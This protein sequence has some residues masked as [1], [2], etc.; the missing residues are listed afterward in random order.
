MLD[1]LLLPHKQQTAN[2]EEQVGTRE[3][4]FQYGSM[5]TPIRIWHHETPQDGHLD[6]RRKLAHCGNRV[7][8]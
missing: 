6:A 4:D 1:V 5:V 7:S 2:N 8:L 3:T